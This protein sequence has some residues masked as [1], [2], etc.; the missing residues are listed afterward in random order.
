MIE[1][2]VSILILLGG[3]FTLLGSI[4]LIR[5]PDVYGRLHGATKSATLG[6]ISIMLAAFLYFIVVE[7]I[8]S[9]KI[10]LTTLF[11]FLTAPVAALMISR[12][13]YKTG[14]PLWEKTIQDDLAELFEEKKEQSKVK[15]TKKEKVKQY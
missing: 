6:V 10:L 7:G 15:V 11:V 13:A 8:F 5:F 9:F 2:I 14:V 4:G 1:I 12:T 3:F